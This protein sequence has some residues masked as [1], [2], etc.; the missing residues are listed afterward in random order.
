M[1]KKFAVK[2]FWN[3]S[4]QSNLGTGP[5]RGGMS[6]PWAVQHCAVACIHE[7]ASCRL[8]AAA[9]VI[10]PRATTFC[11]VHLIFGRRI[12]TFLLISHKP[13][14][15]SWN[16]IYRQKAHESSFPTIRLP[17]WNFVKFS[18][19]VPTNRKHFI[20]GDLMAFPIVKMENENH[21]NLPFPLHDVDPHV[22]QQ[23]LGPPHAPP[24]TAAPTVEAL[25]GTYAVKSPSDTMARPKFTPKSTPSRGPIPKP[26]HLP[27]PWTRPTYDAKRHPYPIRR[28]S[29]MHWTDRRTHRPTDGPTNRL[30]TEKFDDYSPLRL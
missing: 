28:F 9:A 11:C 27:H 29:T 16:R 12:V 10:A 15:W 7:Y 8:A 18:Y 24:Q 25:S 4:V 20:V 26:N 30:S 13:R 1:E 22:I 17:N 19:R 21:L 3:K 14:R 5:R 23:C 2:L 6:G